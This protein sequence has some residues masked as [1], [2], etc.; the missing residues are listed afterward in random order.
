MKYILCASLV[1]ISLP[2]LANAN[3]GFYASVKSGI[4]HTEFKDSSYK[5]AD[6]VSNN[7][8]KNEVVYPGIY[9]AVGYDFSAISPVTARAELEYSYKHDEDFN[10]TLRN[11]NLNRINNELRTQA[12]MLNGFY[13]F[14]NQSA[15]TPYISAGVGVTH[16]RN[17]QT[18]EGHT[19]SSTDDD[20]Q[21]TWSAGVG[22]TY[23]ISKDVAL[24]LSYRYVD[25]GEFNFKNSLGR[26]ETKTDVD[27]VSNEYLLGIRYNF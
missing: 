25:A 7:R 21:F 15:F 23:A 12:L 10:P 2:V 24:D 3:D 16:L 14:K 20:N 4:S 26:K 13:D 19:R 22:A 17:K 5:V 8:S 11:K 27:L 6:E 9:A 18:L 1:A